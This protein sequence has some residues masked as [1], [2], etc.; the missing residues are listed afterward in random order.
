[1]NVQSSARPVASPR[2]SPFVDGGVLIVLVGAI[3]GLALA[4]S[5]L[6]EPMQSSQH[7]AT[8]LTALPAY[9]GLSVLRML[10]AYVLSLIFAIAYGRTAARSKRAERVMLPILDILQSI[11]ILSFMPGIVLALVALFA[12]STLGL[13]LASVLLIFTSQS[14]NMAFGVYQSLATVPRD[15]TEVAAISRFGDWTRLW[16]LELP[17]SA[18]SLVWNS[19]MSWAG[20]WFFLMAS[21]Q[22]VLGDKDFRLPGLGSYLQAAADAGDGA[23][24]L[25]GLA[26]LV[27]V[28]VVLDQLAWRPLVAWSDRFKFELSDSGASAD[29]WVLRALR[30]SRVAAGL[31]RAAGRFGGVLDRVMRHREVHSP[32]RR[33]AVAA[34]RPPVLMLAAALAVG[35]GGWSVI[36]LLRGTSIRDW[37]DLPIATGATFARTVAALAIGLAWTMPFGVW[38]GMNPRWAGRVRPLAQL[39]AS[40]PATALFPILLAVAVSLPAGLNIAAIGLMLLGTQWYLLF[41]IIA[42]A[43]AVPNDLREAADIYKLRGFRRFRMLVLPAIYP[44]VVTGLITATGGA[45]NASIVAEYVSFGGRQHQVAG[46]GSYIAEAAGKGEY[47]RLAA[48]TVVMAVLLVLVNRLV[49]RRLFR[50][51][52]TRF[53]LD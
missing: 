19:M 36:G 32:S 53:R 25:A 13:E 16:R 29:P 27:A 24:V 45:W 35:W 31:R 11:P 3:Y 30:R 52:E 9:A 7:I 12:G 20:G 43:Q 15:L 51:S 40:V 6:D 33:S 4:A 17:A 23:A 2:P 26:A 41:N 14:W 44:F 47:A 18:I 50:L 38:V 22:F 34:I 48:G 8:R 1:M 39:F 10:A 42:G 5:R 37:T 28:I 46:L 21:E 49:W